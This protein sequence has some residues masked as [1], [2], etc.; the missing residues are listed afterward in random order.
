MKSRK[1]HPAFKVW[2][3]TQEGYVF[4]P[5]VYSLLKKIEETGTLKEAAENLDMS[6][7]YAWGLVKQAEEHLGSPLLDA[8]KGGRKGGGGTKITE[9]G[10][11]FLKDFTNLKEQINQ[12]AK[13]SFEGILIETRDQGKTIEI[14]ILEKPLKLPKGTRLRF[15]LSDSPDKPK[16]L[17]RLS[18]PRSKK[19]YCTSISEK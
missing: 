14:E 4:G 9:L 15:I 3:E 16:D 1:P 18:S 13:T 19:L 7:R 6:Y 5:G 11:Q 10:Q 12:L 8:H 2:L 17:Q